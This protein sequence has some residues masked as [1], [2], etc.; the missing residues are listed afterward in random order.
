MSKPLPTSIHFLCPCCTYHVN[1]RLLSFGLV[2][3]LGGPHDSVQR[4]LDTIQK[5]ALAQGPSRS[6]VTAQQLGFF[7]RHG[8]MSRALPTS[9]SPSPY[10]GII[11]HPIGELNGIR[12]RICRLWPAAEVGR[13]GSQPTRQIPSDRVNLSTIVPDTFNSATTCHKFQASN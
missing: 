1:S 12:T 13:V 8:L 10:P 11:T 5:R 9:D 2:A 7:H 3:W 6:R 4:S